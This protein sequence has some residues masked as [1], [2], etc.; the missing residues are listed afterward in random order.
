[1]ICEKCGAQLREGAKFCDACGEK[2]VLC[3]NCGSPLRTDANFCDEC[4]MKIIDPFQ[5]DETLTNEILTNYA[6]SDNNSTNA[7][8]NNEF[9][10]TKNPRKK[11]SNK[12]TVFVVI[13]VIICIFAVIIS[14]ASMLNTNN[15]SNNYTETTTVEQTTARYTVE[16]E[17]LLD[18]SR[19]P[20]MKIYHNTADGIEITWGHKYTGT[21]TIKYATFTLEFKNSVDDPA[22]DTLTQS[23]T[24]E[25]KMTGPIEPGKCIMMYEAVVAYGPDISNV[26]IS[27]IEFEYMDGTTDRFWYGWY[28]DAIYAD[29][30]LSWNDLNY[31]GGY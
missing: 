26:Q 4:G 23:N 18:T 15:Y 14:L 19:S 7:V 20:V 31:L 8:E 1:M 3:K 28:S 2:V 5:N 9:E 11:S 27:E 24:K 6:L 30:E 29:A 25:I 21:K 13:F 10:Q 12:F 16:R 22:Y 17:D